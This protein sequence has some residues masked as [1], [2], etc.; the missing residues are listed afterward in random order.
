MTISLSPK[1]ANLPKIGHIMF[2]YWTH[3]LDPVDILIESI[4][5][6]LIVMTFTLGFHLFSLELLA[7]P[8]APD[9]VRSLTYAAIGAAIAWG[10]I[11][12][13]VYVLA[14]VAERDHARRFVRSIQSAPSRREAIDGVA[15]LLEERLAEVTVE[16]EREQL[17]TTILNQITGRKAQ[18][19]TIQREDITSALALF[20]VAL[21]SA[22]PV[23]L[24]L[25]LIGDP[26]TALR[27][28]N[29]VSVL[30]LFVIG[31][32]WGRHAGGRPLR[33]GL[34]VALTGLSLVLIAVF[35][36]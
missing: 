29:L 3:Y 12:A 10:F 31:Y 28:S 11:D 7:K 33:S 13:A 6:V 23:V 35:L 34:I 4:F 14:S 19:V 18:D 24:P 8:T 22:L 5:S 9:Y 2:K 32:N 25:L 15:E 21:A 16:S 1:D 30:F 20:S 17:A 27:A 36:G 26:L